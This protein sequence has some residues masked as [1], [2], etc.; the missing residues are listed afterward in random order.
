VR[1]VRDPLYY[2]RYAVPDA[3]ALIDAETGDR[4]TYAG[5]DSTVERTAGRLRGLGIGSDD[6]LGVHLGG[7]PAFVR[8]L[9]ATWRVGA[10]LVPLN[11]R[12]SEP[13]LRAQC[14]RVDLDALVSGDDPPDALESGDVPVRSVDGSP[15]PSPAPPPLS[16]EPVVEGAPVDRDPAEPR[17]LVFTSGTTGEPKAVV[18][19]GKNLLASAA[20]SAFRL[21]VLP[22][23][24]WYDPLPPYHMGGIAP[25]VRSAVY[26]TAVVL[27]AG[28]GFDAERALAELG[29]YEATGV[30]LVPTTLD[31]LLDAGDLPDSLRFVLVGGAPT[32]PELVARCER[33]DVPVHPSYGAT[34]T[35]SQV[36]TA[37]PA[38][39][40]DRSDRVGR[41]LAFTRVRAVDE[42]GDLRPPGEP[43]ELVVSGPTVSPGYYGD[44]AA[45]AAAF[46]SGGYRTGDLGVVEPDGSLRVIGRVDDAV[47]TGGEN[48]HPAEVAGVLRSHPAVEDAVVV[49]L[50]DPEW[51][52][53]VCALVVPVDQAESED[54]DAI[55]SEELRGFCEDRLAGYKRPKTIAFADALPRTASGTVDRRAVRERIRSASDR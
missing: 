42:E 54:G 37:R 30:S 29:S 44:P 20:A 32:P 10:V 25:I 48:V 55:T 1:T 27:D 26:G 49:G 7:R 31:R 36:A 53:R 45:T 35:A 39:A 4:W 52:E 40:F 2:Q 46:G 12:L 9:H 51:G 41:P 34:E 23:D 33:R 15:S 3:P 50:P 18:L 24:R 17:L 13:E 16:D 6:Q 22:D 47:I 8:L 21:G 19:T 38:E 5:L 43:G 14:D 11:T 28:S